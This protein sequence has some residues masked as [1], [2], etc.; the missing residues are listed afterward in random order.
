MAIVSGNKLCVG[1]GELAWDEASES[2]PIWAILKGGEVV[3]I[4]ETSQKAS[5]YELPEGACAVAV[6]YDNN[7]RKRIRIYEKREWSKDGELSEVTLCQELGYSGNKLMPSFKVKKA[8]LRH[9]GIDKSEDPN[10]IRF[11]EKACDG[12]VL[13][14]QHI[15]VEGDLDNATLFDK[16]IS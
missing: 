7:G 14:C 16:L 11:S 4:G 9:L 12:T 5:E 8:I 13:N 2:L 1:F 3:K 6:C 15:Q 10:E